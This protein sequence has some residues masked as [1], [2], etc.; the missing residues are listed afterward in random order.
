LGN[1][2]HRDVESGIL[3]DFFEEG[4]DRGAGAD[5]Y[6]LQVLGKNAKKGINAKAR[7]SLFIGL[8]A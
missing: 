3:V 7:I 6:E 1:D 8:F 5:M 4:N 2:G